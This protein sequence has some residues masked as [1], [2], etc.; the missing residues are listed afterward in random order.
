MK[1]TV[2][3]LY[4]EYGSTETY[5]AHVEAIGPAVA[6]IVAAQEASSG[7]EYRWCEFT[8]L[9]TTEGHHNDLAKGNIMNTTNTDSDTKGVTFIDEVMNTD[10][11]TTKL[12]QQY[13]Q[14]NLLAAVAGR[15]GSK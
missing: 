4:P 5:L 10:S 14:A 7:S 6:Q 13:T 11:D 2:L 15:K 1:Y 12:Y 8:V 3:L 9:F